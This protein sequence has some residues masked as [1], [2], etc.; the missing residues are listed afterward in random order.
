MSWG[1]PAVPGLPDVPEIPSIPEVPSLP[2]APKADGGGSELDD[3]I[4]QVDEL[5]GMLEGSEKAIYDMLN[6][7]IPKV[8]IKLPQLSPAMFGGAPPA[9]ASGEKAPLLGAASDSAAKAGAA[10][11]SAEKA[12]KKK[13]AEMKAKAAAAAQKAEDARA[14]MEEQAKAAMAGESGLVKKFAGQGIWGSLSLL[15]SAGL[16]YADPG[17]FKGPMIAGLVAAF[18]NF[19]GFAMMWQ[20]KCNSIFELIGGV[21]GKMTAKVVEVI[22][23]VDEMIGGPL[24]DLENA[25]DDMLEEQKP[26]LDNMAKFETGI[27][28]ID[29]EFN[30]PDPAD[31]K[32]PLDGCDAM[33]DEFVGKAK[34]EVPEKLNESVQS[35]FVGRIATDKSTFDRTVVYLPLALILLVNLSLAALQVYITFQPKPEDEEKESK[36]SESAA[37]QLR[38]NSS[39]PSFRGSR[40]HPFDLKANIAAFNMDDLMPYV[41]PALV[42]ILLAVLQAMFALMLTRGPRICKMLNGAILS[43]QEKLNER[44]NLRIKGAVD[45][46]F[47]VAFTE[48]KAKSDSFFPKMKNATKVLKQAMEMAAKA[49]AMA[50]GAAKMAAGLGF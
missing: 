22:D 24:A 23:T 36:G 45:K 11:G 37:R 28:G 14:E 41:Q 1:L 42:Q 38:G 21:F 27:K 49:Q 9:D 13:A 31:L 4:K 12:G 6:A 50:G 20:G 48:V 34:K 46:V 43:L 5:S 8:H 40:P 18:I 29:K 2:S 19:L 3:A 30:L 44:V 15:T 26:V 16:A 35:T 39:E 32:K 47:D 33:I 10:A 7:A 25:I 17:P